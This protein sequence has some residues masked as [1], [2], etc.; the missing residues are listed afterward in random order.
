MRKNIG[1]IML[2]TICATLLLSGTACQEGDKKET[3][4]AEETVEQ[5]TEMETEEETKEITESEKEDG[6]YSDENGRYFLMNGKRLHGIVDLTDYE[7]KEDGLFFANAFLYAFDEDGYLMKGWFEENGKKYYATDE[8][9]LYV[10]YAEIDGVHYVFNGAGELTT[11]LKYY[12]TGSEETDCLSYYEE[13]GRVEG[14][15][16]TVGKETKKT[17][18]FDENGEAVTGWQTID[19]KKYYFGVEDASDIMLAPYRMVT[20]KATIDGKEY[21]FDENGVLKD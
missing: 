2:G 9:W 11:G 16:R 20:G 14:D 10:S 1:K 12:M 19:G 5:Q 3:S 8:G 7:E 15:W 21:E 17:F 13:T 4:R 6:W 18:Y